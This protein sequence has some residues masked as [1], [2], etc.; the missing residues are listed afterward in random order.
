MQRRLRRSRATTTRTTNNQCNNQQRNKLLQQP[1]TNEQPTTS[2]VRRG[3]AEEH[4]QPTIGSCSGAFH[5]FASRADLRT[6]AASPGK[7]R[8]PEPISRNLCCSRGWCNWNREGSPSRP[9]WSSHRLGCIVL[10]PSRRRVSSTHGKMPPFNPVAD[11]RW[12]AYVGKRVAVAGKCEGTLAYYG[13]VHW[14]Q[15]DKG[16]KWCG[17]ILDQPMVRPRQQAFG[18]GWG[19]L[20]PV[21]GLSSAPLASRPSRLPPDA[22]LHGCRERTTGK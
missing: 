6:V 4:R 12:K 15:R 1:T 18:V 19:P 20:R 9:P 13:T 3:N 22:P 2:I 16:Q 8:S 21:N 7:T 10:L 11:Q 5:T 17:V 14:A